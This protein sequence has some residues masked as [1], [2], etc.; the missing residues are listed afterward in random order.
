MEIVYQNPYFK[1]VNDNTYYS[2]DLPD[3]VTVVP[4]TS[5]SGAF[6]LTQEYRHAIGETSLEFPSGMMDKENETPQEAAIRELREE[7]GCITHHII[8]MGTLYPDVGRLRNKMHCFFA[9]VEPDEDYII[10]ED[11]NC[12]FID[13]KNLKKFIQEGLFQHS[14]NLSALML[15]MTHGYVSL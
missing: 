14:L 13:S 1:V 10:V 2:L 5:D 11:I 6:V 4:V 7:T 9:I 12:H 3:Y 8:H 15:A